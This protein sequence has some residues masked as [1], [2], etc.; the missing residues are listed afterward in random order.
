VHATS[1]SSG[2]R[3]NHPVR[4]IDEAISSP[5]RA[6]FTSVMTHSPTSAAWVAPEPAASIRFTPYMD[7]RSSRESLHFVPIERVLHHKEERIRVGRYSDRDA[8]NPAAPVG[9]KS[10]VVSR[11]HCEFWCDNGQWWVRDVKS[12]SGTF[13]NHIRLSGPG[14][15]SK[16]FALNDG[17]I[18]Q[19][20]IDFKG[21]EEQIFRCV[22]IRVELNRAWQ[23]ALNKFN[24]SA[25]RRLQS[26]AKVKDSDAMSTNS[27]ECAICL[28]SVAPC[29]SL[30][31]APCSHVWHYK[32]IRP[33]I[34]KEYPIFRCPNCRAI[35]DLERD[36]E[37]DEVAEDMWEVVPEGVLND[38][39]D[40]GREQ[41]LD[42]PASA[43]NGENYALQQALPPEIAPSNSPLNPFIDPEDGS[44]LGTTTTNTTSVPERLDTP[45]RGSGV[46]SWRRRKDPVP[47]LDLSSEIRREGG[48]ESGS[49]RSS[50]SSVMR[51][52]GH[53]IPDGPMTPMNDAGPFLLD[54]RDGRISMLRI[55]PSVLSSHSPSHSPPSNPPSD[56]PAVP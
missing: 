7:M 53:D 9:F 30:F 43:P 15:E 27:S 25:H 33:L 19:L 21:G 17:D 13:L 20:G 55:G 29:Q 56:P 54:G 52:N 50:Q 37:E 2:S 16:A 48:S 24:M 1:V 14:L 47:N 8:T 49:S 32:C 12:S 26:L 11:R 44:A 35:A 3:E 42:V 38:A 28:F 4:S 36:I 31:V 22:K 39:D 45:P 6:A 41:H 10:K 40:S 34:E 23:K 5:D 46:G 51:G 18:L